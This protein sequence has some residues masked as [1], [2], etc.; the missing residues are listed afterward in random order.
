MS[1]L[2]GLII[3]QGCSK[4]YEINPVNNYYFWNL[5]QLS[6]KKM[7]SCLKTLNI[8]DGFFL[9]ITWFKNCSY[10]QKHII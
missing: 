3:I 5:N 1:N 7:N 8:S 9:V 2:I 6:Y 4:M 10:F